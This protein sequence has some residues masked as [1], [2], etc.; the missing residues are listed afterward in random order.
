M[1][2]DLDEESTGICVGD[3]SMKI[4][5]IKGGKWDGYVL[6]PLEQILNQIFN[7]SGQYDAGWFIPNSPFS[8]QVLNPTTMAVSEM[9]E[10]LNQLASTHNVEYYI[11]GLNADTRICDYKEKFAFIEK[12]L[13]DLE[14]DGRLTMKWF[15]FVDKFRS[16]ISANDFLHKRFPQLYNPQLF[17]A[18]H[19]LVRDRIHAHPRYQD[20]GYQN[21]SSDLDKVRKRLLGSYSAC[22]FTR[23]FFTCCQR[24][25]LMTGVGK[26]KVQKM[27]AYAN[28]IGYE[29]DEAAE[30]LQEEEA[31][32]D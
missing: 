30:F 20:L 23:E 18:K 6:S 31:G 3:S 32:E 7:G 2:F 25:T 10:V 19:T 1:A 11:F 12:Q 9:R 24:N 27:V 29:Y 16:K 21:F 22:Y 15:T 17:L 28:L 5:P 13:K 4:Y 26:E 8:P 14:D